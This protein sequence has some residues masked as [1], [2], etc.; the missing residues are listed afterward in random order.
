MSTNRGK[1]FESH[2]KHDFLSS[3]PQASIDRLIDVM[4]GYKHIS[5]ICDFIGYSFPFI[6][7][8]ECKSIDGNTFPFSNLSQYNML[9]QKVGLKGVRA[10]V[11][12][13][14]KDH[15]RILY[16]PVSTITQMKKDGKKSVNIR[17][18]MD[19]KYRILE[20]PSVKK[21]VFLESDYSILL[22][23]VDGD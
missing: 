11:V 2:F 3:L 1:E 16:V 20:I 22:N 23:T 19:S 4:S 5:N 9:L 21:R 7:Y 8:L 13:W 10:G 17:T 18:D 14:F 6:F 12:I 15:S